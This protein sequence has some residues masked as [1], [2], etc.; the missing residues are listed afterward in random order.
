[1]SSVLSFYHDLLRAPTFLSRYPYYA[2]ILARLVPVADP[3]VSTLAL[4]LTG[5]A[6]KVYL[7]VNVE[8][9]QSHPQHL[10]GL[11]LHEVH[12][13]VLGHLHLDKFRGCAA[14][15]LMEL[16]LEMSAN[17]HIEEPLPDGHIEWQLFRRYGARAGQST[18]ERYRLLCQAPSVPQPGGTTVDD[19]RPWQSDPPPGA[20]EAARRLVAGAI[21]EVDASEDL[22]PG[23]RPPH[24]RLWGQDPGRLLEE[25]AGT[26][27]P[28]EIALDWRR[29]LP[30]F[31]ARARAPR[32]SFRRP[33][34]RFPERIG[35][36]PGR[37][38]VAT[39]A[40]GERPLLLTA[41]DTSLSMSGD[42]LAEV[43]RQL[44]ALQPLAR[45][46][47]AECDTQVT[48]LYPFAGSL[49]EVHGR[50]G[51]DLR[52]V[53]APAV[54]Q[55]VRP[56]AVVYFTDGQGPWPQ[57]PPALPVLWVLTK[58]NDFACPFGTRALLQRPAK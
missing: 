45:L 23:S 36:V 11:L 20:R 35:E 31:V 48:R 54:L 25:L 42:E 30:V 55:Q 5:S 3:M 50:G 46:V 49:D 17:E 39:L 37:S 44:R 33:N 1:M 40:V 29:L 9:F 27:R 24:L 43:A 28:P 58:P 53:F 12:H 2:A 18:L 38:Y 21:A 56:D 8:Y 26:Q 15:A 47:I 22:P 14:P 13:L 34:R 4:S 57:H 19:H 52:A 51:T 16:A 10:F 6:E 7:H 32:H 41:L